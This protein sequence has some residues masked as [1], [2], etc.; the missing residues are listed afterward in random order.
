MGEE[1]N[2]NFSNEQNNKKYYSYNSNPWAAGM[3]NNDQKKSTWDNNKSSNSFFTDFQKNSSQV[4]YQQGVQPVQPQANYQQGAQPVQPQMNMVNPQETNVL[5]KPL[6]EYN[7][8]M[9]N[10]NK[11]EK[12]NKFLIIGIVII[13]I[14]VVSLFI[15]LKIKNNNSKS[16]NNNSVN[17]NSVNNDSVNND[18]VNDTTNDNNTSND[19]SLARINADSF[20][21]ELKNYGLFSQ[22]GI[23]GYDLQ[24]PF[25]ASGNVICTSS[26]GIKWNGEVA[27]GSETC[28]NYLT[29]IVNNSKSSIQ[30]AKIILNGAGEIEYGTWVKINGLYCEYNNDKCVVTKPE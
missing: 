30:E 15:L 20:F 1:Q 26:D 13:L 8:I 4:N 11:K 6:V 9:N 23:S 19:N 24:V 27:L 5:K 7:N 25:V 12:K 21:L 29:T 28:Q 10:S 18:S 16:S 22:K 3:L 14:I 2:T 17:N